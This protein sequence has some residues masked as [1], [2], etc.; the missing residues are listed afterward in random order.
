MTTTASPFSV[1]AYI[2]S[3]MRIGRDVARGMPLDDAFLDAM[4][5]VL[6]HPQLDAAFK[7]LVLT[8]PSEGV[9][10]ES[11]GQVD[12][13][14]IHAVRDAAQH[15]LA[16]RLR[17]DWAAAFEC[18]G[19][20]GAYSPDPASAGHRAL[21]N[22]SLAMLCLDATARGDA[23]WPGRAYQ[24]FKDAGN[25]TDRMGALAA[26]VDAHAELAAPALQHFHA[27]FQDEALAIDKWFMLQARAP[28]RAGSVL[29]RVKQLMN[30]PDFS[31]KS[32]NRARSLVYNYCANNPAGFHRADAAG[33]VYW[34]DR[35]LELDAL[36]PQVA[37]RLA[38]VMDR[39]TRLVEPYRSAAQKA[40][41]RIAAKPELSSDVREI[42]ERSL[43]AGAPA[44]PAA[45]P[46][47]VA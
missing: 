23:V 31:L 29:P 15:Q 42:V 4:R 21:A 41:A 18:H 7:E 39:W 11:L 46:E 40:L 13:Q 6:R 3:A 37:A 47:T 22:L 26:L 32:P 33:Y 25:M 28:D 1:E 45:V 34:A 10:A 44:E 9:V 8:L 24:R 17:D 36:N 2:A 20:T 27:V 12:P 5:A 19:A 14:R 38:R 30:H 43:D 35:V 16:E